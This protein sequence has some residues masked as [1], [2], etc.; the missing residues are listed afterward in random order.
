M[1][2]AL[3]IIYGREYI[4]PPNDNKTDDSPKT[5]ATFGC[6][7]GGTGDCSRA[8]GPRICSNAHP[9]V[10]MPQAMIKCL[11]AFVNR[12]MIC[13]WCGCVLLLLLWK[14]ICKVIPVFPM[15][16]TDC[17]QHITYISISLESL[18]VQRQMCRSVGVPSPCWMIFFMVQHNTWIN[19]KAVAERHSRDPKQKGLYIQNKLEGAISALGS[20][21][22][23]QVSC[24]AYSPRCES[25]AQPLLQDWEGKERKNNKSAKWNRKAFFNAFRSSITEQISAL[26]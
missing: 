13:V 20:H 17:M 10:N 21:P 14:R 3:V 12:K 15:L 8:Y 5:H 22:T 26:H 16:P 6:N 24:L 4:H 2:K 25:K 19:L 11:K 9:L 1:K 7:W 23:W 18:F